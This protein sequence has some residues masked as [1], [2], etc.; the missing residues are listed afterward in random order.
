MPERR[1]CSLLHVKDI[2]SGH[3]KYFHKF[4]IK[5]VN[6]PRFKEFSV[7]RIYDMVKTNEKVMS[8]LPWFDEKK[9]TAKQA[10]GRQWFFDLINTIDPS[11]FIKLMDDFDAQRLAD[12]QV[13]DPEK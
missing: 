13:K 4:E 6:V 7:D 11:F 3:K 2:L 1:R 10:Y 12:M 9:Y 8:Y 5:Q